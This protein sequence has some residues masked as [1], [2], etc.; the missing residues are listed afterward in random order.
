MLHHPRIGVHPREWR[1]I[2]ESPAPQTEALGLKLVGKAHLESARSF[3][4]RSWYS[5]STFSGSC[6]KRSRQPVQQK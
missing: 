3:A 4:F 5:V 6:L 1:P 2:L